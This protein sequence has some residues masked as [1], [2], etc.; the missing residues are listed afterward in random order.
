MHRSNIKNEVQKMLNIIN[1]N[2]L[3]TVL[4]CLIFN[5]I[6]GQNNIDY[7]INTT[8]QKQTAI[9]KVN[10]Y[11]KLGDYYRIDKQLLD[12]AL[13]YYNLAI[14]N[15]TDSSQAKHI[16]NLINSVGV[17]YCDKLNLYNNAMKCFVKALFIY[18]KIHYLRGISASFINIGNVL[19]YQ[20]EYKKALGYFYKALKIK[21]LT[22]DNKGIASCLLN[23]GYIYTNINKYEKALYFFKHALN[24]SNKIDYVECSALLYDNVGTVYFKQGDNETNKFNA[25]AKY[26]DAL[27][28]FAKSLKLYKANNNVQG[29]AL[30]LYDIS[31]VYLKL[32]H[33]DKAKLYAD[34]SLSIGDF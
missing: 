30:V 5:L 15:T 9:E 20:N 10:L 23:I 28:S 19:S 13:Y 1:K 11:I 27:N 25:L 31:S 17:S 2:C 26:N 6:N 24:I 29:E 3:L 21:K 16:A 4:F 14:I 7:N 33:I 8:K 22:N 12:S 32:N 18:E 34:S